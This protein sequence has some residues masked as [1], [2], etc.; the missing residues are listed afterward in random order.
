MAV[1]MLLQQY[2]FSILSGCEPPMVSS[3]IPVMTGMNPGDI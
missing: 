2:G 1:I 3:T